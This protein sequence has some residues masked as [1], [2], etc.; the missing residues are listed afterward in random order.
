MNPQKGAERGSLISLHS[1]EDSTTKHWQQVST[2]ISSFIT[3]PPPSAAALSSGISTETGGGSFIPTT[4]FSPC[5]YVDIMEVA[6]KNARFGKLKF[7]T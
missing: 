1:G 3:V 5:S 4:S 7:Y 6:T 2:L